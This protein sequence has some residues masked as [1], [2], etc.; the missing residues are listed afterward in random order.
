M[1]AN[2]DDYSR[3]AHDSVPQLRLLARATAAVLRTTGFDDAADRALAQAFAED[4]ARVAAAPMAERFPGEREVPALAL[5][6]RVLGEVPAAGHEDLTRAARAAFGLVRWTEFYAE[7]RWSRDFLPRFANG[8]GIGPDGRLQHDRLI[9]GLFLLGPDTLYPAHAHPA[10]EFYVV[11]SGVPAFQVG[12]GGD[13]VSRPPGSVILH[14]ADV[15][16]AIRSGEQP[17]FGVFGWRGE[18]DAPSW[19]RDDM[20]DADGPV[21]YPAIRKT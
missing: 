16:H 3:E 20:T 2:P 14:H 9:L 15:S 11:V 17:F 19:Y 21:R 5:A 7:D 4:L 1:M 13:F 10:D 18:I 12:A 8:E 6:P